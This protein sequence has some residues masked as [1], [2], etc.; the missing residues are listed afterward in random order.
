[1]PALTLA[2]AVR[3]AAH[4]NTRSEPR[5]TNANA[6][7]MTSLLLVVALGAVLAGCSVGEKTATDGASEPPEAAPAAMR[8]GTLSTRAALPLWVAEERGYFDEAGLPRFEVVV[9]ASAQERDAAFAAGEIDAFAGEL[10]DCVALEAA[11]S[12]VTLATV[13]L[14]AD[15][16]PGAP[17]GETTVSA[18]AAPTVMGIADAFMRVE[19]GTQAVDAMLDAWDRAV[20]DINAEPEEF[21]RLLTERVR[22]PDS[23]GADAEIGTYPEHALPAK[24]DIDAALASA[25]AEGMPEGSVTYEDLTLVMPE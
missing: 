21:R 25:Q 9:F 17:A 18:G 5:L 14:G 13:M 20:A 7:K 23:Q 3:P 24:A 8:L 16:D 6:L 11:G 1:M 10:G 15:G 19:G 12:G 2:G 22:T 4:K